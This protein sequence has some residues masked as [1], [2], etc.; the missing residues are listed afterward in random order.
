VSAQDR[1]R[2]WALAA[3]YTRDGAREAAQKL[4]QAILREEG[5]YTEKEVGELQVKEAG[6]VMKGLLRNL[7]EVRRQWSTGPSGGETATEAALRR[8]RVY[9]LNVAIGAVRRR[10]G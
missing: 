5:L 2:E 9:G 3:G 8:A 4:R 10:R 1:L 6:L 7:V